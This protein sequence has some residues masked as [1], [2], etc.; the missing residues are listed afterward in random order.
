MRN[1]APL[2]LPDDIHRLIDAATQRGG[3][4]EQLPEIDA[5]KDDAIASPSNVILFRKIARRG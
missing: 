5:G 3:H 2:V 1:Y 4:L